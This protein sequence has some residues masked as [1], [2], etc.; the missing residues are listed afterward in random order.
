MAKPYI[1]EVH[2]SNVRGQ[3]T[4]SLSGARP[5]VAE[6]WSSIRKH[7]IVFLLAIDA[8]T[9]EGSRPG[10]LAAVAGRGRTFAETEGLVAVRGAEVMQV[11]DGEGHVFTGESENDQPLRGA[12]RK[13]ELQLDSAQYHIDAAAMADGKGS[14]VYA[15]FNVLVR[16]KP[17]E[18]NFKAILQCIRSLMTQPLVVPNWLL[19]VL[20]GY[21]D[22]AAAAY[23][24]LPTEQQAC[25]L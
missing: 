12:V 22:P 1:G 25:R 18:N 21:G 7:D 11:E 20:L 19:D 16:R 13:L 6:E 5:D 2:P 14:N 9:I 24:N 4:I 15:S 23:W 10:H 17:K 8:T 3:A